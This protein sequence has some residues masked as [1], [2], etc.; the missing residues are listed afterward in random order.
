MVTTCRRG[1][2]DGDGSGAV[3]D[4]SK[5]ETQR[6]AYGAYKE[7]PLKLWQLLAAP[8]TRCSASDYWTWHQRSIM[9]KCSLNLTCRSGRDLKRWQICSTGMG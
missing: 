4:I 2:N 8:A 5:G 6:D 1:S 7:L 9:S 3:W